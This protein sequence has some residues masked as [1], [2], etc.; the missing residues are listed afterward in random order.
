MALDVKVDI[1]AKD[2]EAQVVQA[3]AASAFGTQLKVAV[4][5]AIKG[6]G[7]SY[8]Y[9]NQLKKWVEDKMRDIVYEYVTTNYSAQVEE[10]IRA[11]LST[12]KMKDATDKVL[13]ALVQKLSPR[14]Y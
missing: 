2:I 3:I 11:W 6:L 10:Q 12:E 1:S 5:Q 7:S 13:N 4:E 14:D 9:D 8:S